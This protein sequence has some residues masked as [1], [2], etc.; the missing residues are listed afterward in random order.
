[1]LMGVKDFCCQDIYASGVLDIFVEEE[2][3]R[4]CILFNAFI[5]VKGSFR[6]KNKK[7]LVF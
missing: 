2:F 5:S 4:C 3:Y 6:W 7:M 1:M